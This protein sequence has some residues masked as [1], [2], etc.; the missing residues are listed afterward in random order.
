MFSFNTF[1]LDNWKLTLPMDI[2]GDCLGLAAEIKTISTIDTSKYFHSSF[3]GALVFRAAVDG[4]TTVGS[5]FARSELREMSGG[6]EAAWTAR[7]GGVM[8]AT[9]S[10]NRTP[11]NFDGTA[12]RL[13]I[14]Q[15]HGKSDELVRLYY[16]DGHIYFADDHAGDKD[17]GMHFE[18]KNASGTVANIAL[19]DKFSYKIEVT[20]SIVTVTVFANGQTYTASTAVNTIWQEDQFYFKAGVY[21][22]VNETM[23]TGV[24]ETSFY[25]L[26]FGHT[27]GQGLAGLVDTSLSQTSVNLSGGSDDDVVRGGVLADT[28]NGNDGD[29][30]INGYDGNDQLNG[31]NGNDTLNGGA[32]ND[33]MSGGAGNDIYYV[34][35]AADLLI[36]APGAGIDTVISTVS[37]T[38][39]SNVE[40]LTL[41]G[42]ANLNASGNSLANL[43]IGNDGA[44]ILK[45]GAGADTMR[46]GDGNDTYSVDNTGDVVIELAGGGKDQVNATVSYTLSDFVETLT[47]G[48]TAGIS[49][50][51]NSL[52][53]LITGNSGAN[54]LYGLD[55]KD[56]LDG[57]AGKDT[58]AGGNGD[59]LYYVDS[60]GDKIVELAGQGYDTVRSTASFTLSDNVETLYLQGTGNINGTGNAS[61][62]I[63]SGNSSVNIIN[64]GLGNDTLTGGGEEDHFV[65]NTAISG[66]DNVDHIT[67]FKSLHDHI[68][69][70]HLIFSAL[71]SGALGAQAFALGTAATTADQHIIYDA[72]TGSLYYDADGS[73]AQAQILFAVFDHAPAVTAADFMIF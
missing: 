66:G 47:L 45:G 13:V 53:N 63:V 6:T 16:D 61:A 2:Y 9:L 34:D 58:M 52:N 44:N 32:G 29:D 21:L 42:T 5:R 65:F 17:A 22:G 67:D 31:G 41:L 46:G 57:G 7:Q 20:A 11:T 62:N 38:L 36:E 54:M 33:T 27:A 48:G 70:D 24:G 1:S 64:G 18:V 14:G 12:G 49:G 4:A 35:S 23:A 30:V 39:G 28:L 60:T 40:N 72:Q 59:D 26:D 55:G 68:D 56:T 25:G 8:T 73:G 69:L 51:G 37:Y 50:T 19:G 43:L 10:V 3:D 15:V 71:G